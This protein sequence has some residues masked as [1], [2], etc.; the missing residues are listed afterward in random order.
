MTTKPLAVIT[1]GQCDLNSRLLASKSRD[2]RATP[3]WIVASS[4]Y[5][6]ISESHCVAGTG[7]SAGQEVGGR[8]R[9]TSRR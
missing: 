7:G 4:P 9:A 6:E 5:L 3:G 2:L 8:V 1:Q